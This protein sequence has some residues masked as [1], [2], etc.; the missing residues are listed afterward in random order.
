MVD[1]GHGYPIVLVPGIQGRW[2]WMQPVVEALAARTRV[3]TYTLCGDRGSECRLDKEKGFENYM[4]Q[5]DAVYER[6]GLEAA[7]LCGVSYGGLI[8]VHY[9]ARHPE[10]VSALVLASALGPRWRLEKR[11]MKYVRAPRRLAPLFALRSLRVGRREVAEALPG[12]RDRWAFR[13]RHFLRILRAP[14]SP[15]RMAERVRFALAE[16]LTGDCDQVKAPTLVI[17][18]EPHLDQVVPVESTREYIDCIPGAKYVVIERTGHLG[19]ITRPDRF[20]E[21]VCE[22]S[23]GS[24]LQAQGSSRR[25]TNDQ[26]PRPT[27]NN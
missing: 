6:A 14:L 10:R 16:D 7:A 27:T 25:T 5:L 8:A 2:E 22:F 23:E 11:L 20:A 24:G 9:A 13:R 15:V 26:R 4:A 18:G 12:S 17:T 1:L 3:I 19:V 21:I